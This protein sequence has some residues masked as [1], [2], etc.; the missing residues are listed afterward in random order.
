TC[1]DTY[2][3]PSR[4]FT[5][6]VSCDQVAAASPRMGGVRHPSLSFGIPAIYGCRTGGLSWTDRGSSITPTLSPALVFDRLFGAADLPLAGRLQR[7]ADRRSVLDAQRWQ[8]GEL[9]RKLNPADQ[10]RLH[11]VLDAVRGVEQ[12]IAREELWIGKPKPTV[13]YKRPDARIATN[14]VQH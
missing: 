7:L 5:N 10:Q 4:S 1:A 11:E 8:I 2:S 13:D 6:T 12:E 9:E 14:T 3:D